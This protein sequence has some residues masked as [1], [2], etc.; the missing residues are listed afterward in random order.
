[1]DKKILIFILV[2]AV[3]MIFAVFW[4][5]LPR[6][7]ENNLPLYQDAAPRVQ[8]TQTESP[9]PPSSEEFSITSPAFEN[10]QTIPEKYT[11]L[12][13]GTNPPLIIKN[14][15]TKAVSLALVVSDPDAAGGVFYH[16]ILFDISSKTS[17][18][19]EGKLPEKA[20]TGLNSSKG[21]NFIP[22]CPPGGEHRYFFK[23]LAL[24]KVL[25]LPPT[26]T[27]F[28]LEEAA[29]GHIVARTQIIGLVKKK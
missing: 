25:E 15:P 11:C 1:M 29:Q 8:I 13:A 27:A 19:E 17:G 10:L 12:G 20:R 16:W 7:Q 24:D 6:H 4:Y 3:I 22:F 21:K 14:V 18:I 23:L 2:V 5:F 28:A 9:I 26:T